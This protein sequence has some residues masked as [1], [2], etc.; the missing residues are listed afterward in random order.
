MGK[1]KVF[2]PENSIGKEW[3]IYGDGIGQKSADLM[4][5]EAIAPDTVTVQRGICI[6]A[7][8]FDQ[9]DPAETALVGDSTDPKLTIPASLQLLNG[10]LVS[11]FR[12]GEPLVVRSSAVSERVS[13]RYDSI[14]IMPTGN[15]K[16]DSELLARAQSTVYASFFL[17]HTTK[18]QRGRFAQDG[19]MGLLIQPVVGDSF[20]SNF[21][22]P[23]VSGVLTSLNGEPLM[24]FNAGMGTSVV[25]GSRAK[26]LKRSNV[27]ASAVGH[28]LH[29][30]IGIDH[31]TETDGINRRNGELEKGFVNLK[32]VY[33]RFFQ[34]RAALTRL[35]TAWR[36]G[37][38][39]GA[40]Y[41]LEFAISSNS[42]NPIILQ[43]HPDLQEP[44][45]EE[46]GPLEGQLLCEGTDVVRSGSREGRG[47]LW[48][49]QGRG[50]SPYDMQLIREL[51]ERK[52]Y[53][54]IVPDIT[55]S[56]AGRVG[57]TT[58]PYTHLSRYPFYRAAGVVEI[59][60][61][62][63]NNER[64]LSHHKGTGGTH[65][66][67][68]CKEDDIMFLGVPHHFGDD[69]MHQVLGD[70]GLKL[71]NFSYY[72]DADFRISASPNGGRVELLSNVRD[73]ALEDTLF[74]G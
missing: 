66:A 6:G 54:L 57:N 63:G 49:G 61:T 25:E 58:P 46:L 29:A 30:E 26:V 48:I 10:L 38:Q 70:R 60:E 12:K 36:E 18:Q 31:W 56:G 17:D 69:E 41:Y 73:I 67:E 23:I 44:F 14:F 1:E 7:S 15:E 21:F 72:Y 22:T 68:I 53:L 65:F 9:L 50:F 11:R 27:N 62:I 39:Q 64:G 74:S 35:V 2:Q 20:G 34:Q 5:Y 59:Q 40:P 4:A 45:L 16:K 32:D 8:F 42:N 55:I 19:G 24:R 28:A 33:G 51:N 47:I 52:D 37:T 13:G 3:E 43:A 71:G